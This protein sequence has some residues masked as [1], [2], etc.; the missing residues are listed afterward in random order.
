MFKVFVAFRK[1][2]TFVDQI[3]IMMCFY[4]FHKFI[5]RNMGW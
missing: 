1:E 2:E 5:L 3:Y 4:Y